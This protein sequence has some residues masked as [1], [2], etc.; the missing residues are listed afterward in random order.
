MQYLA[1]LKDLFVKTTSDKS[2]ANQFTG[3]HMR[4]APTG[5]YGNNKVNPKTSQFAENSQYRDYPQ[6]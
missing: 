2:F 3:S 6:G 4:Q 5:S 1:C